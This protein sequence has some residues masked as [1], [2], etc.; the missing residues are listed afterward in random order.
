MEWRWVDLRATADEHISSSHNHEFISFQ[1]A[2]LHLANLCDSCEGEGDI[3]KVGMAANFG[4]PEALKLLPN[5]VL[6]V[7]SL[8]L[9]PKWAKC[10]LIEDAQHMVE[11]ELECSSLES[12]DGEALLPGW[13]LV[14]NNL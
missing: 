9:N 4:E 5:L 1:A 6:C 8:I 2:D 14:P 3:Y 11:P 12:E 13:Q 7:R 10:W